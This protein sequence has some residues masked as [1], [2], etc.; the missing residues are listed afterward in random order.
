MISLAGLG[1]DKKSN[2]DDNVVVVVVV[3]WKYLLLGRRRRISL[4]A[5]VSELCA[6]A[7]SAECATLY[8]L[9]LCFCV[10]D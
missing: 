7:L 5:R 4:G 1:H 8:I 2:D 10:A 3:E 6:F 9:S